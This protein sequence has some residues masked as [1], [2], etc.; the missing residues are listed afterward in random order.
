MNIGTFGTQ[1]ANV[2]GMQK[3]QRTGLDVKTDAAKE[4]A[5]A[6]GDT[7]KISEEGRRKSTALQTD[8]SGKDLSDGKAK[9]G[10]RPVNGHAAGSVNVADLKNELQKKKTEVKSKKAKL[11]EATQAAAND[12]SKE[13]GMKKLKNQVAELEKEASKIQSKVYSS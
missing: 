10:K 4:N 1:K 2:E 7:V 3:N 6:Q 11:D 8:T 13:A 12:P 5:V 9:S